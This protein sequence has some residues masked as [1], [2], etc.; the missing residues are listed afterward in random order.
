MVAAGEL[1]Y[2]P[3]AGIVLLNDAGLVFAARR[4][5][6]PDAWQMP[7]GGIDDGETPRRAAQREL[8]EEIGTDRAEI[9]AQGS[10]WLTYDLPPDLLGKALKGRFRGQKQMW[11]AMRFTGVDSDIDI[12]GVAHPEFE[13][14]R[15]MTPDDILTSIVPFKR[16]VYEKVFSEFSG[17]LA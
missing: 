12:H 4:I 9:V 7:Q 5:D 1:P 16:D 10:D 15:W 17:L 8:A 3:C 13:A 2:R 6:M 14:W 11:F